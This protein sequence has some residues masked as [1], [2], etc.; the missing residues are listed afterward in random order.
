MAT[1][2]EQ[3]TSMLRFIILIQLASFCLLPGGNSG[4]RSSRTDFMFSPAGS[5]VTCSRGAAQ[6]KNIILIPKKKSCF[7][8]PARSGS[9]LISEGFPGN[10]SFAAR[11]ESYCAFPGNDISSDVPTGSCG[12]RASPRLPLKSS[13]T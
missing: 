6:S 10:F 3:G 9:S 7:Q 2:L 8:F 11:K 4:I 13:L 5:A 12:A 1:Q